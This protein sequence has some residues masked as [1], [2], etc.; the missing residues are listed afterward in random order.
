MPFVEEGE[1][2]AVY[3]YRPVQADPEGNNIGV[4]CYYSGDRTQ[5]MM[6]CCGHAYMIIILPILIER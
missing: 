4:I 2:Q 5:N 1:V 3:V 6:R